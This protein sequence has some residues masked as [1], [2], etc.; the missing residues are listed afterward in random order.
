MLLNKK[1]VVAT[2]VGLSLLSTSAFA[3][4][5]VGQRLYQK[6]LKELCGFSGAVFAAKHDQATWEEAKDNGTL[7][8]VMTEVCPGGADFFKSEKFESKFSAPLYDFVNK[9]AS[10]SGN[11]P[12]C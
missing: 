12:S 9:F 6:K 8:E 3:D 5:D 10:D 1:V 2:L 11:I 7:G 4:A